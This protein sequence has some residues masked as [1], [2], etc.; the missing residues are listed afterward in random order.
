LTTIPTNPRYTSLFFSRM[1]SPAPTAHNPIVTPDDHEALVSIAVYFLMTT[2]IVA[3]VIRIVIRLSI[4]RSLGRDDYIAV[5]ATV[6]GIG[7][8]IAVLRGEHD[9]LGKK[10]NLVTNA[11]ALD[12]QKAQYASD[13]L[14]MA[15]LCLAKISILLLLE[16]LAVSRL[17]K[18]ITLI[19][20]GVVGVWA[21]VGI[22]VLAA[23]CGSA[24]PWASSSP[25]CIDIKAFWI[26]M[27]VPDILT[28]LVTII[29]PVAMMIPVQVA[30]SKK[31]VVVAAFIFRILSIIATIVRLLYIHPATMHSPDYT[32]NAVNYNIVTQC[33]L[34]VCIT[35]ACIP[36]LKPFLDSFDSGFMG[37]SFKNRLPGGSHSQSRNRDFKLG[38]LA[39]ANA[40]PGQR[41]N[42][43]S[44][45]IRSMNYE[46]DNATSHSGDSDHD[47]PRHKVG[48]SV[49]V[50]ADGQNNHD[51]RTPRHQRGAGDDGSLASSSKS[52][53]MIIKK[54][55]QYTVQYEQAAPPRGNER[56]SSRRAPSP[57]TR[58][59]DSRSD[60]DASHVILPEAADRRPGYSGQMSV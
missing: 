25:K 24:V 36:C 2:F 6:V 57:P 1:S 58:G 10:Q 17:H 35:T 60:A 20:A 8:A 44:M 30:V 43:A 50:F 47:D 48:V 40:G 49:Q 5:G 19:T 54:N 4:T 14:Y 46:K 39:Y 27:A 55:V 31:A 15:S 3:V 51:Q 13:I 56:S 21:I 37:I 18:R 42:N 22:V 32:F 41:N 52:D 53:Q 59:D 45:A 11:Q 26:G 23:Q 16:R 28:E 29:I 12:V 7:Q 34:S 33:V 38:D 9:G